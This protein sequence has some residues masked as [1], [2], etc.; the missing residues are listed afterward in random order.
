MPKF[1]SERPIEV[2]DVAE[3]AIERDVEHLVCL[4]PTEPEGPRGWRQSLAEDQALDCHRRCDDQKTNR[5][6]WFVSAI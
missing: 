3:A 6:P 4:G 1:G 5:D 2:G